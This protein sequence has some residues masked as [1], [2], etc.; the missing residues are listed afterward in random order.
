MDNLALRILLQEMCGDKRL[1]D[2]FLPSTEDSRY[3]CLATTLLV[4][5]LSFSMSHVRPFDANVWH[6][7]VSENSVGFGFF[8][9]RRDLACLKD[10][11]G[12]PAWVL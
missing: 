12:G 7:P 9:R 1:V 6:S 2:D 8:F 4:G 3:S 10:F 5:L 11:I